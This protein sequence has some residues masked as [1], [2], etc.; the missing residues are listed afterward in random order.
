MEIRDKSLLQMVRAMQ[1]TKELT[2]AKEKRRN[3][4]VENSGENK[5]RTSRNG[6]IYI[7]LHFYSF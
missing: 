5:K 4:L 6:E 2:V 7:F 1:E 3:V